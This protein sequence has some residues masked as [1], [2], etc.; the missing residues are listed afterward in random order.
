MP[1]AFVFVSRRLPHHMIIL[2]THSFCCCVTTTF[3]QMYV[4]C[5]YSC[6][7]PYLCLLLRELFQHYAAAYCAGATT[8][9]FVVGVAPAAAPRC[10]SV[11]LSPSDNAIP[12]VLDLIRT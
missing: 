12:C 5:C 11:I 6:S 10:T 3:S 2:A 9:V 7:R 8:V 1:L 4:C